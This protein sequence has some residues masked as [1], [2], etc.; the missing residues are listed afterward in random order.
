AMHRFAVA[1][2]LIRRKA[3]HHVLVCGNCSRLLAS[4]RFHRSWAAVR[5]F[6]GANNLDCRRR[7]AMTESVSLCIRVK[8][9]TAFFSELESEICASSE[10]RVF[11]YGFGGSSNVRAIS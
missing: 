2:L 5:G 3:S 7:I 9:V 6:R 4:D 8:R 1:I 11:C 10:Y